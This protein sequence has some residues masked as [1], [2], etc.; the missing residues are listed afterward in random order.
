MSRIGKQPVTIPAGVTVEI[1]SEAVIA[2]NAKNTLSV[3]IL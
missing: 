2:K 3:E 1:T